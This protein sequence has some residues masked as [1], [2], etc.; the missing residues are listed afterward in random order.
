MSIHP[1]DLHLVF[2]R[3]GE[4]DWNVA[5]RFQGHTDTPLNARGLAQA[6]ELA[7]RC[8]PL[9]MRHIYSSDLQRAHHTA[10]RV[11]EAQGIA[12]STTPLLREACMGEAEGMTSAQL[13]ARV[14]EDFIRLWL[15]DALS[16]QAR[17]LRFPGGESRQEVV[18]RVWGLVEGWKE[19]HAGERIGVSSH[20]GVL[21]QIL[22]EL[23]PEQAERFVRIPNALPFELRWDHQTQ[24][25]SYDG[26]GYLDL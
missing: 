2:F 19:A 6:E 17:G 21:R 25:W 14:G 10:L 7:A 5:G 15:R 23:C 12:V 1:K 18:D 8:R 4:T 3:H 13:I 9:P 20:G 24:R 16:E 26:E 22:S 11:A